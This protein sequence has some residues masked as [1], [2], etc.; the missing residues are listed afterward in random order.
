MADTEYKSD[1][2]LTTDTSYLAWVYYGVS[3]VF[4]ILEE[5]NHVKNTPYSIYLLPET[6]PDSK[7]HGANVGPIWGRQDPGGPHVGRMNLAI[8]VALQVTV[9]QLAA[10]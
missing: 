5:R 1:F 8:W 6:Y 3:S 7:D 2:K 10:S 4:K 9:S